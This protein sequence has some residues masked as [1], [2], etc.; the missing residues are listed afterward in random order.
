M[1]NESVTIIGGGPVGLTVAEILSHNDISVQVF[2]KNDAPSKEWRAS[3]FHAGTLELLEETGVTEELLP[4]GIQADKVQYRDRQNG[5]YAEFDFNLLKDETKYP[6]RLQ[7]PQSTYVQTLYNRLKDKPNVDIHFQSEFKGM[8]QT[9]NEVIVTLETP[10]GTKKFRSSYLLG[11]DGASSKVRKAL[12]M[13]FEGY[14]LEER[15]LLVGTPVPFDHYLSDISYVNYIADPEEFLFILKVPEAWRLL[16]PISS[17]TSEEEALKEENIQK[18]L[19]KALK[20]DDT[21]P[22]VEKM[23]YRVHQRVAESFYNHRTVLLGDAAHVNSPMGGL[24]LNNGIH[25]AVDL[26]K[27]L[28]RLLK[29]GSNDREE[30]LKTYNNVR[31]KVAIDYIRQISERN[32]KVMKEK[33]EIRRLELQQEVT[34]EANN[35]EKAKKWLLRSAMIASVREQGIGKIPETAE[36]TQN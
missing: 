23:I 29:E 10:K 12:N 20:T 15:F 25:D 32:T 19:Q 3:T 8:E 30:E 2:E 31:K 11:A 22:I 14:T 27:R 13:K 6:F 24:G 18:S 5:L 16:Y 28:V 17:D 26:S 34:E 33:D 36:K 35:P 4:K 1:V 7:C 21:F 9:E